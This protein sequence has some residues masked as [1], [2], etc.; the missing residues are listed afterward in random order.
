MKNLSFWFRPALFLFAWVLIAA[1]TLAEL[2]T[3]VPLLTSPGGEPSA[4][5][6][7]RARTL[8]ARTELVTRRMAAP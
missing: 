3:V 1:F 6:E 8:R 5:R 4:A 2:A 7:L